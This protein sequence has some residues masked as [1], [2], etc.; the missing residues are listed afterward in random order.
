MKKWIQEKVAWPLWLRLTK[1]LGFNFC[2][3]VGWREQGDEDA[4][5]RVIHL[6]DTEWNLRK[7][8]EEYLSELS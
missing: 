6:Y 1:F 2:L 8:M 3:W 5:V 4:P 7:S